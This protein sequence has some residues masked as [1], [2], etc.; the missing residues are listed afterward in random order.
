[1]EGKGSAILI[2]PD[3]FGS[4][5]E[6]QGSVQALERGPVRSGW[7]ISHS[8]WIPGRTLVPL[9]GLDSKENMDATLG[10]LTGD[11]AELSRALTA[12]GVMVSR[13]A[14][15][16]KMRRGSSRVCSSGWWV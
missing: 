10:P 12:R 8:T 15:V 6:V 11:I 2:P 3:L 7:G 9:G 1:M 5:L 4:M 14:C 13:L 16:H